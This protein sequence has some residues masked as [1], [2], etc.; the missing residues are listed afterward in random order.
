[1]E[2]RE[3]NPSSLDFQK[4]DELVREYLL[5]RGFLN[6]L[7]AFGSERKNDKVKGIQPD[8]IVEQL[9]AHIAN[10]E[11]AS[12]LDLWR[13]LEARFFS[14]LDARFAKTTKKLEQSLKRYYIVHCIQTA[15][16][17]KCK[18]FF[19]QF[20]DELIGDDEWKGWFM[21]P[22]LRNGEV[23]P[24]FE[25]Y[26]SK[27][28]QDLFL[29]SI[30][31]FIST[32][33]ASVPLPQIVFFDKLQRENGSLMS[34]AEA[35]QRELYSLHASLN[36]YKKRSQAEGQESSSGASLRASPKLAPEPKPATNMN[37]VNRSGN[38][39]EVCMDSSM[40]SMEQQRQDDTAERFSCR[41]IREY[42]GHREA[43]QG[44]RFSPDGTLLAACTREKVRVFHS[45]LDG[46]PVGCLVTLECL[47]D[48]NCMEWNGVNVQ[49]NKLLLTGHTNTHPN[50][51]HGSIKVWSPETPKCVREIT[52]ELIKKRVDALTVN[53]L[54]TVC[55]VA[56]D[57]LQP[58]NPSALIALSL[59]QQ[60]LEMVF[61]VPVVRGPY[62]PNIH[63]MEFNHNGSCFVTGADDGQVRLFDV[64]QR[65][66]IMAWQAH[67][68]SVDCVHWKHDETSVFTVGNDHVVTEW[69]IHKGGQALQ[70]FPLPS[71]LVP[72]VM[73]AGGYQ[74]W[75]APVDGAASEDTVEYA[76][77][78][79]E[80][81]GHHAR[82]SKYLMSHDFSFSPTGS[83]LVTTPPCC[84]LQ[85][86]AAGL[87]DT[88]VVDG[89]P[90]SMSSVHWHPTDPFLF[91]GC[92]MN[93]ATPRSYQLLTELPPDRS[94][95][96]S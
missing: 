83:H 44:L 65:A 52:N 81:L 54:G 45:G 86:N 8:R 33:L 58:A 72:S 51:P 53:P 37:G 32:V 46:G 48:I 57:P 60:K 61:E 17:A 74:G 43:V 90:P 40:S 36:L 4:A 94:G 56:S 47:T 50:G 22:F 79:V 76:G 78:W 77:G 20:S 68:R 34:T 13:Y 64:K 16:I 10:F 21:L 42:R 15:N 85:C 62:A 1:M 28:W 12:L 2:R 24:E 91:A 67:P 71:C 82:R 93:E 55:V 23:P 5:F 69:S 59:R 18:E 41:A 88:Q 84:I 70:S 96:T 14:R 39:S 49:V 27:Q 89:R 29:V 80:I 38:T 19:E 63:T 26:F 87:S 66:H 31:N 6:T 30:H 3:G 9:Q 95:S 25:L 75:A 35:Q 73:S 7:K 11:P 92:G